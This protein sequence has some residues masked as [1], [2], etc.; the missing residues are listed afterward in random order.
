M[1]PLSIAHSE[2]STWKRP[3]GS[4]LQ[5]LN[6]T[7]HPADPV[8]A[9]QRPAALRSQSSAWLAGSTSQAWSRVL[10]KR[11]QESR[12]ITWLCLIPLVCLTAAGASH[13]SLPKHSAPHMCRENFLHCPRTHTPPGTQPYWHTQGRIRGSSPGG[14]LLYKHGQADE[15]KKQRMVTKCTDL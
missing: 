10:I 12:H 3:T 11:Y 8:K 6:S 9:A 7:S 1:Q 14:A 15:G 13:S 5:L 4:C 2:Y